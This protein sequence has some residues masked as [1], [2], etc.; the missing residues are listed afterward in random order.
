MK[1]VNLGEK[2]SVI[3]QFVAELRDVNIQK[4]RMRFRNNVRRIGALMAY[5]ISKTLRYQE[6]AVE[7]PLATTN[8]RVPYD[9]VVI[10]TVFR[11][12]LPFHAGFLD[13]FDKAGNAFLSAY[14]YYT[15]REC[16]NI[17]VHIEYI[18]TPDLTHKTFILVDPMLATG[19]SLVL[20]HN[21]FITKG[22]P[23]RV[24]MASVIA[25]EEGIANL[26]DRFPSN[27]IVLYTAAVDPI[28]NERKYIVP[29]LGDAGDL[30][31]GDKMS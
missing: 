9:N 31:Y 19:E 21:A 4:D 23:R 24:V 3:N 28:L 7:T 15:D 25:T 8:V 20:A 26:N 14:R 12:G 2:D 22:V 5:E 18:A 30:M 11:A 27:D 10:G 6:V 1:V 13:I 16:N 29:G 17:D